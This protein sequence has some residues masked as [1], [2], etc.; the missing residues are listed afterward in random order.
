MIPNL[1][2]LQTL[3]I[4]DA[5]ARLRSYSAAADE[6][7]LTHGAVSRQIKSLEHWAGAKLFRRQGKRMEPTAAALA[8]ATRTREA[9]HLLADAAPARQNAQAPGEGLTISTTAAIARFWLIPRLARLQA[10][11]PGLIKALEAETTFFESADRKVDMSIRYGSG[12]WSDVQFE[13]I[14]SEIVFPVASPSIA[15]SIRGNSLQDILRAPLIETPYQS[16][17]SWFGADGP[18]KYKPA[19]TLSD[20]NLAMEAALGGYGVALVRSRLA[21]RELGAG[22]LVRIGNLFLKDSYEYYAVW[23]NNSRQRKKVDLLKQWVAREMAADAPK[24]DS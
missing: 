9:L 17:R 5:A 15:N 2:A 19:M 20:S 18:A 23:R 14:G 12:T 4:L 7:G 21:T 22:R 8:L 13:R 10:E 11:H 6:L 24:P 1:P 16:W 3:R